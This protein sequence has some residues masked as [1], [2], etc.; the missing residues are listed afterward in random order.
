MANIL[1]IVE[2]VD[3][4][5]T[6]ISL[7]ALAK[8][9]DLATAVGG[10]VEALVIGDALG[11]AASLLISHGADRVLAAADPRLATYLT[12]PFKK[13]A[14][15]VIADNTPAAV[16]LP[17]ST[18][19]DDLAP[20]LAARLGL[21]CALDCAQV[22]VEGGV[23]ACR[24]A[25]FDR[26]VM[27]SY[28]SSGKA[29]IITVKDG[30]A[31]ILPA[32]A[33]RQGATTTVAV[34]LDESDFSAKIIRR[35]VATKSVNLKAAS[36]IVAAGA[37]VGSKEGLEQV[38]QLADALGGQIGATR[39]VVD[40]GWLPADHQIGQTGVTVRPDLYIG[41]GIS[42]AVQ[43]HVGMIDSKKIVAIN[44]DKDAPIFKFAHYR[45][46][47]DVKVVL[48]KLLKLLNA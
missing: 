21:G 39:A 8:A 28:Q 22:A 17:A 15:A 2:R 29:M 16:L 35:D 24:R 36:I 40:A 34:S 38:K 13:I 41:C 48:P 7:Q 6:D 26:K 11:A 1:V 30:V 46:V 20:V 18:M 42:G 12:K 47:G 37:G 45:L 3:G 9:R 5:V 43:H 23:L 14:A 19:G 44:S 10:A 4:D 33:S 27:T 31:E 25:E 32:D